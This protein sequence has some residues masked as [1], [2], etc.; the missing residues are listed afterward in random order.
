MEVRCIR[1]WW[2][3]RH[4]CMRWININLTL[5]SAARA[6]MKKSHV[7]RSVSSLSVINSTSGTRRTSVL[8]CGTSTTPVCTKVRVSVYSRSATGRSWISG[9]I[10]VWRIFRSFRCIMPRNVLWSIWMVISSW[11]MTTVCRKNIVIRSKWRWCVSVLWAAGR[12][13]AQ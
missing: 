1:T 10:F 13:R 7:P 9:S 6:G 3:L 2:R 4:C 12:W 11:R 8:N 5:H